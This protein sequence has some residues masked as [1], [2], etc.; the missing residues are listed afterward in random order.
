[1]SG[2]V[3]EQWASLLLPL[4]MTFEEPQEQDFL[5]EKKLNALDRGRRHEPSKGRLTLR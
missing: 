4:R 1:M 3:G 2:H 5:L